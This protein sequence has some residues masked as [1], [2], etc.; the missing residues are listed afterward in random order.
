MGSPATTWSPPGWSPRDGRIV[1]ASEN[2]HPELFSL[3]GGGG[4][5]AS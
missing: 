5:S 2:E 3:R 1:T 4:T